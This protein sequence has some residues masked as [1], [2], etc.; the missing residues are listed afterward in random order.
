MDD[1]IDELMT[2]GDGGD[3]PASRAGIQNLMRQFD[4]PIPE[5]LTTLWRKSDGLTLQSFQATILGPEEILPI[6][7]DNAWDHHW[8]D[9]G[10]LPFLDDQQ[11]NF[12]GAFLKDPIAFRVVY[13]PH[14]DSPRLLYRDIET[15]FR[16]LIDAANDGETADSFLSGTQGDYAPEGTRS[17]EDQDVGKALLAMEHKGHI[18]N[19]AAQLLDASNIEEWSR[20]LET[21]HF[22]RRDVRARL[23]RISSPAIR[24]LLNRDAREFTEFVDR[25]SHAAKEARLNVGKRGETTLQIGNKHYNMEVFFHRRNIPNA[26]PRIILWIQDGLAGRKPQDRPGHF[27]KDS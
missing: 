6:L 9:R 27:M 14:D 3:G 10:I 22:V 4:V 11:S 19:F 13:L 24:E 15:C 18:W 5:M 20:L 16:A 2:L 26:L 25:V 8:L 17:E 7:T 21:D 23:Q 1:L 12:L